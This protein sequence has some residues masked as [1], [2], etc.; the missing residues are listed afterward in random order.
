MLKFI[1]K[2]HSKNYIK[3][4]MLLILKIVVKHAKLIK[5]LNQ[6]KSTTFK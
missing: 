4:Y 1:Y 5:Q 6:I 3:K 2:N